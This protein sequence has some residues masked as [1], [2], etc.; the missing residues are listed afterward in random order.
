VKFFKE[1]G[2]LVGGVH[3]KGDT[4]FTRGP[5]KLRYSIKEKKR[6]RERDTERGEWG[7][8]GSEIT[9]LGGR[10][11]SNAHHTPKPKTE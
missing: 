4:G 2:I 6:I 11:K 8:R 3:D 9:E 5:R 7:K 10:G 1:E